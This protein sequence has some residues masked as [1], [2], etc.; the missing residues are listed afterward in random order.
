MTSNV[1]IIIIIIIIIIVLYGYLQSS[2]DKQQYHKGHHPDSNSNYDLGPKIGGCGVRGGSCP[3]GYIL[4]QLNIR[5]CLAEYLGNG[6]RS[7]ISDAEEGSLGK[8]WIWCRHDD[9]EH[10]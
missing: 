7:T 4:L 5:L 3:Y 9:V 2:G 8:E 10:D 6:R 1:V